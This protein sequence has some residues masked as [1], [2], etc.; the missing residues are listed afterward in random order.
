MRHAAGWTLVLAL[1][2]GCGGSTPAARTPHTAAD[3]AAVD[4]AKT[5]VQAVTLAQT[6]QAIRDPE[7]GGRQPR[8]VVLNA[9]A[10]WCIPCREEFPDLLRIRREYAGRGVRLMFVSTDFDTEL[11]GVHRFLAAQGVDFPTFIKNEQDMA[12]IDGIEPRWTGALPATFLYDGGG[13]PLWF[14]EGKVTYDTL[15]TRLDAALAATP[16]NGGMHP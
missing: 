15:K 8:L 13:H 14:H 3:S 7:P 9:W 1:V 10:T 4:S 5:P 6:L 2:A 12:F 16:A 11:R